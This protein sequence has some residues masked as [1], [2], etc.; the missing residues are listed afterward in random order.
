M[1]G[2]KANYIYEDDAGNEWGVVKSK[3]WGSNANSGFSLLTNLNKL[4]PMP[5]RYKP[6]YFYAS[7]IISGKVVR[8]KFEAGKPENPLF[9]SGGSFT[10]QG[11]TWYTI[12]SA[13]GEKKFI[14]TSLD[15]GQ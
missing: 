12:G 8:R 1:A 3:D 11:V 2:G 15:T 13:V 5:R 6:R 7:A 14:Y 4:Q 9:K 10:H